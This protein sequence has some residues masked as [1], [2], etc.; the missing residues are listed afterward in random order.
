MIKYT[1]ADLF[2][3]GADIIAHGCNCVG[4]FGSGVAGQMARKYPM[5]RTHYLHK[6]ETEGWRL[7]DVQFVTVENV[8]VWTNRYVANC[9]TQKEYYPRDRVHADYEAIRKCMQQVH[10]FAK[11]HDL[12]VAIPKIGAGLAGGDW[13]IIEQI[14][15]SVFHDY[16]VAVY[17]LERYDNF[18]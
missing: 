8:N 16:N 14:L 12:T 13:K 2:T 7:G 5:T 9:A 10:D 11:M 1:K 4:G 6:F 18:P 17:H 15:E 3:T